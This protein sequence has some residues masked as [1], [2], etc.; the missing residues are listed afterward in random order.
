MTNAEKFEEVFGIKPDT[1]VIAIDCNS[2][3]KCPYREEFDC[4][5]RCDVWWDEK[6]RE[7]K[8]DDK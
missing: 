6:Y 1:E 7:V 8:A 5:C 4:G 3:D 2:W